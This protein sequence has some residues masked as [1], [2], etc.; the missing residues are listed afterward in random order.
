MK[1]SILK[2]LVWSGFIL[3]G[4]LPN[5]P[6]AN[7]LLVAQPIDNR[8]IEANRY[9]QEARFLL[10]QNSLLVAKTKFEQAIRIYQTI[11]D[12]A[13]RQNCLIGLARID[14][15]LGNYRGAQIKLQQAERLASDRNGRLLSLRGLIFIELGDYRQASQNLKTG[16]HYLQVSGARDK[17]TR[18]EIDETRIALGEVESYLGRYQQASVMLQSGLN[19]TSDL[20]LK[21][22]AL[23]ALGTISLELGQYDRALETY[24]QAANLPNITGDRIG[25]AQTLENLG[26][27]YRELGNKKQAL[28][29]YQDALEQLRGIGA[30]SQQ[31]FVLNNLG[32][33]ATDLGLSNRALKYF[34]DAEGR[35]S[36][37]GGVGRVITLT[38]LGYY[39]SEKQDYDLAVRYLKQALGWARQNGDKAGEAKARSGLGEINLRSGNLDDAIANLTAS[40]DIFE[41]LRPGLRDDEKITLLDVQAYTYDLLQQAYVANGKHPEALVAAE[42]GR[43]RAFIELLA[44]RISQNSN[45]AAGI[46]APKLRQITNVAKSREATLVSYSIIKNKDRQESELY[47]WVVDPE[48]EIE[49]RR[50]DLEIIEEKF[51]TTLADV[52]NDARQAAS[53]GLDLRKPRLQNFVASARGQLTAT[54][55]SST[56]KKLS[57]PRDAYKLLIEPIADLLPSNPERSVIFIPQGSLFLVPFPALQ[58]ADGKFLIEQ[59]TLKIA[60]SIQVLALQQPVTTALDTSQALIVGNPTPMPE[61]FTALPGAETEAKNIAKILDVAP[62][63]NNAATE[64]EVTK[65][66]SQA[67]IIHLATHG[68]FDE[69]QGL[70]SSLT[71]AETEKGEGFLTAEEILDLE[72]EAELVVLSACNTGRGKITGD[73][74]IGLSRSF[75]LAGAQSAMVSLWYIP[76]LPTATLMTEFYS[77]LQT[78]PDKAS[79]LRQAMLKVM[80]NNPNPRDWASF[81]LIGN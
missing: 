62:L 78:Q 1:I 15:E 44:K 52:S 76:D 40:V 14:Y 4:V 29:H 21:R 50:L 11:N 6:L 73:G 28:K 65:R 34:Q 20:H 13:G 25:K 7:N 48:G 70:Q 81:M 30:W 5:L 37:T 59:H 61:P 3:S 35:L 33:L 71:L 45:L 72:L 53:G 12:G 10:Q 38:N 74:V 66:M 55:T 9:Y 56:R 63:L 67:K 54:D 19:M 46:T 47:I 77:N 23:N 32:I 75:L 49:F 27:V 16:S 24:Q 22:R 41:S 17:L 26:R 43:A 60:P 31:V 18:K 36:S 2:S 8:Q 64:A 69:Q 51:K 58:N 68:L 57:F 80:Q 39:Y 42:R 79:A